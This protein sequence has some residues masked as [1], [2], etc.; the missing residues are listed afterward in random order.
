MKKLLLILFPIAVLAAVCVLFTCHASV[1]GKQVKGSGHIVT[2]TLPAPDYNAVSASH[3]LKVILSEQAS[4]IRIDADDNL[5]DRVVV[6]EKGG[7]LQI[8]IDKSVRSISNASITV[9]APAR[10]GAIRSLEASSSAEIISEIPLQA[11]CAHL[12]ASSAAKIQADYRTER[13]TVSSSSCAKIVTK[14]EASGACSLEASSSADIRAEVQAASCSFE[15]SCAAKIKADIKAP[16]C[17]A[18]ASSA[19]TIRLAGEAAAF[20]AQTSSAA[21]IKAEELATRRAQID[22]SS[23]SGVTITCSEELQAQA[24]S[25]AS[26]RYDGDCRVQATKSSGGNI[27]KN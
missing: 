13:C 19:A 9:T 27:R 7:T 23:G 10:G 16:E 21:G 1:W 8:S 17:S 2:R 12:E 26:I 18:T 22:A 11:D 5:I 3:P 14:I 20:E 6:Q 15:A 4:G 24:S 25:G